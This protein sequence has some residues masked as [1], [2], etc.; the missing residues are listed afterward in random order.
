MDWFGLVPYQFFYHH[1]YWQ[2]FTYAF[3]HGDVM[4]LFFNLI[5]LAFIGSEL[6]LIW[7]HKQFLKYY[8][9]CSRFLLGLPI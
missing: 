9:F 6:E 4:H 7:G 2:V 1:R 5:M 3:L 8:F